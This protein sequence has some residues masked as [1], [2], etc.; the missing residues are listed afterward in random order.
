MPEYDPAILQKF[1]EAQYARADSITA[2]WACLGTVAGAGGGAMA[3]LQPLL[4]Q[5]VTT[6]TLVGTLIGAAIGIAIGRARA[7][8]L[9]LEAQRTLCQSQIEANTRAVLEVCRFLNEARL[10]QLR[11]QTIE[12]KQWLGNARVSF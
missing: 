9:K 5:N 8:H 12:G 7:F 6:W 10:S 2:V 1:A 4:R 3:T 11:A